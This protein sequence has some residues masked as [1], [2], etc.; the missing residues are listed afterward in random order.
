MN[1]EN[2]DESGA[3]CPTCGPTQTEQHPR[4]PNV[5]RC[6]NCKEWLDEID[7]KCLSGADA[8]AAAEGAPAGTFAYVEHLDGTFAPMMKQPDGLWACGQDTD[9]Q[10]H[11]HR[12]DGDRIILV[13]PERGWSR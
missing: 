11:A 8:R 2:Q 4:R 13:D 5:T 1:A 3:A 12:L 6:T 9:G 10:A 7:A